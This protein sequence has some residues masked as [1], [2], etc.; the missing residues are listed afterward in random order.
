MNL[1]CIII[2]SAIFFL[3]L[4]QI[5]MVEVLIVHHLEGLLLSFA[6]SGWFKGCS[7]ATIYSFRV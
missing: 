7:I 2:L 6:T 3:S 1:Q 5:N 4:S